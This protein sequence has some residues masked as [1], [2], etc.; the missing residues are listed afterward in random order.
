MVKTKTWMRWFGTLGLVLALSLAGGQMIGC[1]QDAGD[2][3]ED[4]TED[5]EDAGESAGEALEEGAEDLE[6]GA[7]DY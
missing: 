2:Q 1:E 5:V 6:E 3:L 4:A 7:E